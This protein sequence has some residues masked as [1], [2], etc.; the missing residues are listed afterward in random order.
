MAFD[1]VKVLSKFGD[2]TSLGSGVKEASCRSMSFRVREANATLKVVNNTLT[3]KLSVRN[4]Y[5]KYNGVFF[6]SIGIYL[7]IFKNILGRK[8]VLHSFL[9]AL[10]KDFPLAHL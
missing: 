7:K 8:W 9:C 5:V 2:C 3:Y 10:K 1:D 6:L 4:A